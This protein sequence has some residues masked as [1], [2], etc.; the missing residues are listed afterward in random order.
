[1]RVINTLLRALTSIATISTALERREYQD[2]LRC[3]SSELAA[4]ALTQ[5]PDE[6]DHTRIQ[7]QLA[8][9]EHML[10]RTETHS[11]SC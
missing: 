6:H 1:M 10:G 5:V 11:V 9:I 7:E 2:V 8:S 3:V 4:Q